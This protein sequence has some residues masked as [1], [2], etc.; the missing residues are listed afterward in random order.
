MVQK[1]RLIM[2]LYLQCILIFASALF[3]I[4]VTT[5]IRKAK[6]KIDF[7]FFWIIFAL[8]LLVISIFPDIVN[9]GA[10]LAGISTPVTFVL[11]L[12][13]FLLMYKVFSLSIHISIMQEKIEKLVQELALKE[14][15]NEEK[16]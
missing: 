12:I 9:W 14:K 16:N 5:Q 8:F 11:V 10:K 7:T 13:I 1:A 15:E 2:P 4:Y 3:F 6:I